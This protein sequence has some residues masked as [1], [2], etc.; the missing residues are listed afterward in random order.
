VKVTIEDRDPT[1]AVIPYHPDFSERGTR[2]IPVTNYVFIDGQDAARLKKG[3]IFRL[4]HVYNLRVKKKTP[5]ELGCVYAGDKLEEA[6]L[7][8]QW[9]TEKSVPVEMRIP[10]VLFIKGEPNPESLQSIQG[11]GEPALK[12]VKPGTI[13]QLERKGFGFVDE[14]T[15]KVNINMTE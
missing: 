7:K 12:D 4:K 13:I 3:D 8:I 11:R 2:T 10:D 6:G 14:N 15:E 5:K 1:E 9:V